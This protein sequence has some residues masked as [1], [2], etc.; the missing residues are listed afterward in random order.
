[1]KDYGYFV[2]VAYENENGNGKFARA[3]IDEAICERDAMFIGAAAFWQ[4]HPNVKHIFMIEVRPV[5]KGTVFYD[6][7]K[8]E[9]FRGMN[10]DKNYF[11]QYIDDKT[12]K[13]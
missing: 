8:K 1:M 13:F 12:D 5:K 9:R 2:T 10:I 3:T 7:F 6:G 11:W 4:E